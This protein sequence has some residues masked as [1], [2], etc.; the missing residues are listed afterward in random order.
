M[1]LDDATSA[2]LGQMAETG[3]KPLH[4]MTPDEAR[5]LGGMLR[6]MY[7]PGPGVGR[8]EDTVAP[9]PNGDVPVRVIVPEGTPRGLIVYYHGGGWVIG[10]IEETDHLGRKMANLTRCTVVLVDYRLAPEHRYPA[11]SEDSWAALQWAAARKIELAGGDVPLVV[12]G[13]SA[14]GNLAAIVAQRAKVSG[15]PAVTAQVLVYPVTDADLDN[16]SYTDPE[17]QLLLSRES[18]VWFWDHYAPDPD[19]RT[20]ADAS[21]IR[22]GDLSGLPPAVVLTAE[23]DPLRDEGEAYAEKLRAAG[24]DVESRRFPGQMHGFFTMVGVLPGHDAGLSYVVEFL[25]KHLS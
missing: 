4:E 24:V 14:G 20:N 12:A 6:E 7:G 21:P 17:N 11:A 25:E 18:M 8:V 3:M 10:N 9:G 5:G 16:A 19:T 15:G 2:L 23:H 22:S 1:A 13:D